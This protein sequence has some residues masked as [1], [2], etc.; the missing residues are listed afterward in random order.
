MSTRLEIRTPEGIAFA[1]PLAGPASR[2]LAWLVDAVCVLTASM[3]V[4]TLLGLFGLVSADVARALGTL[5][6]FIIQMGY[7]MVMEWAWRGQ[8][9]GKRLLGLR[10]VD[11]AG[12][13]LQPGQI[14][15]RN[16]LRFVDSLPMFYAV[17]GAAMLLNR[18]YQ[19]LGDL[20]ANTVVVRLRKLAEPDMDRLLG[21]KFNSL[22]S[23]PHLVARLRQRISAE[24]ASVALQALLRRDE[25]KDEARVELFAALAD[26]F[27]EA[28]TFP[29]ECVEGIGDEQYVRNV[30]DVLYR[31][32]EAKVRKAAGEE[33][34]GGKQTLNI[35]HR[36]SNIE[37]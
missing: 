17:G 8:T 16:L 27:R 24:E 1:L 30:A 37:G 23:Y 10:V 26:H 15:T 14:V 5:S 6:Y 33:G 35:E 22:R 25:I 11:A 29:P 20:A 34:N 12:L 7:G 19:R 36:T 13:R 18:Y 3:A 4:G 21:G 28:V 9:I 2:F 32:S 31:T